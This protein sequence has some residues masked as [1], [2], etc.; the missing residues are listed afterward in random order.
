MLIK[1][2]LSWSAREGQ[3][4]HLQ[5]L[6]GGEPAVPLLGM[7]EWSGGRRG[8]RGSTLLDRFL[9]GEFTRSTRRRVLSSPTY[10][11]RLPWPLDLLLRAKPAP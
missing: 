11:I 7:V 2:E 9:T 1:S 10:A 4:P 3:T 5:V 8:K 6:S